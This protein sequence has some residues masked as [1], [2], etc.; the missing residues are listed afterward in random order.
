LRLIGGI[1]IDILH[2]HKEDI[3]RELEEKVLPLLSEGGFLPLADGRVREDMSFENYIYYRSL[4]EEL[5][6]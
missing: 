1:D 2:Y 4:L 6:R 3:R 5:V